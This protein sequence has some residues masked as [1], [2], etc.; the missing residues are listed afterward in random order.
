MNADWALPSKS[1]PDGECGLKYT[2]KDQKQH[3]YP[4]APRWGV[5]IEILKT[6]GRKEAGSVAPRWGVWIEINRLPQKM[7]RIG[8]APRWGVWIEIHPHRPCTRW[9]WRSLPDGECGL[10]SPC[11][12]RPG[13]YAA[14][15]PD[16]E[17]GLK[18]REICTRQYYNPSLPDGECGLKSQIFWKTTFAFSSLPDGECG[19]KLDWH[20]LKL[21]VIR[22]LPDGECGLKC[23]WESS[24]ADQRE[25]APRWGVWI[26]IERVKRIVVLAAGRSPMGSVD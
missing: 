10:K 7:V 26:E 15:L 23:E 21:D 6:G 14:S 19:L 25:V 20:P 24:A 4:V 17:C 3:R 13:R 16:G 12:Q 8:V 1:L 18:L 11:F 2:G 5:W 22:S 9:K